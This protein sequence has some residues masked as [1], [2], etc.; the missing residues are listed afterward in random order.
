MPFD[1]IQVQLK[2]DT[3]RPIKDVFCDV[4][5]IRSVDPDSDI[6]IAVLADNSHQQIQLAPGQSW[7]AGAE[8]KN[9]PTIG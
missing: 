1:L 3:S 6:A 4:V 7:I 2:G 8:M 9:R 5:Q